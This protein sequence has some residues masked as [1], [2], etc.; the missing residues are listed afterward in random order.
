[1][2]SDG[3]LIITTN[4]SEVTI[5]NGEVIKRYLTA[6]FRDRVDQDQQALSFL[7]ENLTPTTWNDWTIRTARPLWVAIDRSRYA[8]EYARGRVLAELSPHELV[9]GELLYGYWVADYRAKLLDRDGYGPIFTDASLH[10]AV[11]DFERRKLIVIDPGSFWG[12]KGYVY[13]E[14]VQHLYSILGTC[15]RNKRNPLTFIRSFVSGYSRFGHSFNMRHYLLSFFREIRAK[16]A[17]FRHRQSRSEV[18]LFL[19][20]VVVFSPVYLIYV[21]G[22]LKRAASKPPPDSV[23]AT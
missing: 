17:S 2:D 10:N 12:R 15:V 22:R 19:L 20:S 11:I 1:M 14:I 9:E 8:M 6:D 18:W 4:K 5:S 13:E 3:R 16:T 7:N 23:Q 21:P